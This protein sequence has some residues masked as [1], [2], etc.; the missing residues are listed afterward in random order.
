MFRTTFDI[1]DNIKT[2]KSIVPASLTIVDTEFESDD[3]V[4]LY[5]EVRNNLYVVNSEGEDEFIF[6]MPTSNDYDVIV[7]YEMLEFIVVTDLDENETYAIN[8]EGE[9]VESMEARYGSVDTNYKKEV[10]D[11]SV[12]NYGLFYIVNMGDISIIELSYYTLFMIPVLSI[13][14]TAFLLRKRV[15]FV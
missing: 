14:V 8:F 12:H 13:G 11:V 4:Y 3:F 7:V 10:G 6:D 15:L 1:G 5:D 2:T 9:I